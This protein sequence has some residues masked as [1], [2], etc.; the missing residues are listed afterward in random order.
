EEE[1]KQFQPILTEEG[2]LN[3]IEASVPED[4]EDYEEYIQSIIKR[5]R[6]K[7]R[8][9]YFGLKYLDLT[10]AFDKYR[11]QIDLGKLILDTYPK[12]LN[13]TEEERRVTDNANAF[14]RLNEFTNA[15]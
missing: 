11:F 10:N 4:T 2:Q 12:M 5:V 7:N 1:R 3:V 9:Y 15:E 13:E 8:F 6:N 14:G